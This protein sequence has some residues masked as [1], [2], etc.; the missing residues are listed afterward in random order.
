MQEPRYSAQDE[1]ELMARLWSPAIKDNPLAFVMFNFPWGEAG[2]PLEHFTGP[3]KWQ[4]QVL[5]DLAEH[6]KR[7][8]GQIDFSVLRLAI[9]SGR[10]IGKSALVS[11]L[12]LWMMTTRIGSTVIVSANSESQL[13]SVTWAEITKWSSMSTNS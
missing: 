13:R 4:R 12:V 2:T 5:I 10:G 6:I 8:N 1:M 11:W 7:N 9:A 3:R